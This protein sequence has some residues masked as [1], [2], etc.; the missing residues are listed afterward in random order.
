MATGGGGPDA[1]STSTFPTQLAMMPDCGTT[2]DVCHSWPVL[3]PFRSS[4]YRWLWASSLASSGARWALVLVLSLQLVKSTHSSFWVGLGLF[5]TQGPVILLLP[6]AGRLA[7]R[8]DRRTLNVTSSA[9]SAAVTL[10]F[11][12]LSWSG[13]LTLPA[14][15]VLSVLYGLS[16]VFQMTL[17]STLVPNLV[18]P[19]ELLAGISLF[20]V[21]TLGAQF[22]GPAL[23]TPLLVAGGPTAGWLFCTALYAASALLC[24][25]LGPMRARLSTND[26][27]A[28]LAASFRYLRALP[29]VWTAVLAVALHCAL[30]M[31]YQGMLPMFVQMDLRGSDSAYGALLAAIGLGAVVGSLLL[32]A[33]AAE[34]Y[35]AALF[36]GS[37]VGSGLALAL[38]AAAGAVPPAIVLG[39]FVGGTQA[40]F[41]SL[42]L[43]VVQGSVAD[44]YRGRLTSLYQMITLTPMAVFGWG[45]GGLADIAEPRPVMIVS[46][47][48][49]LVLMAGYAAVSPS[50]RM[51]LRPGGWV[52]DAAGRQPAGLRARM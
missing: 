7:D 51:L 23:A 19:G 35:R 47:L 22:I 4:G 14:A 9:A 1:A 27:G 20:Q 5:L 45:M 17:R 8:F 32:S 16:F 48:A 15:L 12:V 46:G 38:M 18:A 39:F 30:T 44:E 11:A 37:L 26:R 52:S 24:I 28:G 10:A 31:G 42:A 41:M 2:L 3:A 21:S 29:L 50:L 43:A 25:P 49:F 34:R 36:V 33:L 40:M 13:L 6:V